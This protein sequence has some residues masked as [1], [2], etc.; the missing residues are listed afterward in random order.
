[1]K[2]KVEVST[3]NTGISAETHRVV[4]EQIVAE[5]LGEV[6]LL[7]RKKYPLGIIQEIKEESDEIQNRGSNPQR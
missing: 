3:P 7:M 2:F 1:M 4:I 6:H 5:T